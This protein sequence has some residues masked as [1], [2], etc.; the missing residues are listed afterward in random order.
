[1]LY[2]LPVR[3]MRL[4]DVYVSVSV[5]E[6]CIHDHEPDVDDLMKRGLETAT[7]IPCG[8]EASLRLSGAM[9]YTMPVSKAG[10]CAPSPK[11]RVMPAMRSRLIYRWVMT[12]RKSVT[13]VR[14]RCATQVVRTT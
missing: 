13:G 1:M 11:S 7:P 10:Q 4:D 9:A 6:L 2:V 5:A 3:A 14:G 12:C 8:A